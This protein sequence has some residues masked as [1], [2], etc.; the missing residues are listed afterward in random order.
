MHIFRC[1]KKNPASKQKSF[2]KKRSLY[3]KGY[4]DF[5]FERYD[6]DGG[7]NLEKSDCFN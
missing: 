6:N 5:L 7:E 1:K 2:T 4:S 3:L